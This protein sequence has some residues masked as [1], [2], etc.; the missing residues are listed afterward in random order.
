MKNMFIPTKLNQSYLIS[1]K[2]SMTTF[3]YYK[4]TMESVY[5]NLYWFYEKVLATK[6][7]FLKRM[8]LLT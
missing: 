2:I 6:K 4:V 8:L 1:P 3:R 7:H 5:L